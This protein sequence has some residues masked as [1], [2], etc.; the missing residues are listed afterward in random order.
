MASMSR[1]I[2]CKKCKF[3]ELKCEIYAN[4]I[5]HDIVNEIAD[6]KH[7]ERKPFTNPSGDDLPIAKG[8]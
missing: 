1:C 4:G 6:C 5:P 3:P 7:Y 2:V 8:R